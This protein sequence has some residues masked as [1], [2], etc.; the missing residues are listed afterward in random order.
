MMNDLGLA[1][2]PATK[3]PAARAAYWILKKGFVMT[4]FQKLFTNVCFYFF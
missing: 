4:D 3:K 2:P 1:L